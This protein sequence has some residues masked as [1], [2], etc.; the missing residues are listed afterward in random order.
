MSSIP[1]IDE[2]EIPELEC[3]IA[4]SKIKPWTDKEEAVLRKYYPKGVPAKELAKYLG[5]T[6]GSVNCKAQQMGLEWGSERE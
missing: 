1:A 3:L 5:R 4:E 6:I 2:I